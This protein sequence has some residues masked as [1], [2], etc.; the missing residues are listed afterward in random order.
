[1]RLM[2]RDLEHMARRE[3][4]ESRQ[5]RKLERRIDAIQKNKRMIV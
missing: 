5:L 3:L 1:M 4:E 2:E